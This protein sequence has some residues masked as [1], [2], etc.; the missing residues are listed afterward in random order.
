MDFNDSFGVLEDQGALLSEVAR[1]INNGVI[2]TDR[3]DRVTWVNPGFEAMSGYSLSE[4]LGKKPGSLLH[5]EKTDP[6]T[7]RYMNERLLSGDAFSCEVLHYRRNAEPYW[8]RIEC[9][10]VVFQEGRFNGHIS[11]YNDITAEKKHQDSLRHN[12][13]IHR[14]VLGTLYDAVITTDIRGRIKSVNPALEK[15]FGYSGQDL[16]GQPITRLMPPEI[17]VA[18]PGFMRAYAT[19]SRPDSPIMGNLR[20][21]QGLRS[22][23]SRFTLRIAVT[24]TEVNSERLLVAALHDISEI[25]QREADLERFRKTLDHTLDC[26]FMFDAA[27]LQFFY[28]NRGAEVQ[29]GYTAEEMMSMH[30]YDIKPEYTK[31]QFLELIAPLVSGEKQVLNFQTLHR[32]KT[33]R[34]IPV[35]VFLQ[36][37][38]LADE[39]PRFIAVV[40]DISEQQKQREAIEKLAYYDPLTNLPNRR[41]IRRALIDCMRRSAE[42]GCFCAVM[43][44]DL[45]DFKTVNDTLGHRIGDDLLIEVSDRFASVIGD[46]GTLARLGGDEFLIVVESSA[47]DRNKTL[48]AITGLSRALL[49]S[50][51]EPASA[52]KNA[53]AISTSIGVVLFQGQSSTVSDLMRMADIAMYD[54]KK[55][56][57]NS[58]SVFGEAMQ[59]RLLEEQSMSV[60]LNA[61]LSMD[62]EIVPWFQIKVD[63]N[64]RVTGFEALVRWIHPYRGI[65]SPGSF[66]ELAERQNLMGALSDQ[67]LALSCRT[68]S[69]WRERFDVDH[70]TVAV[71]VSQSQL[72]TRDFPEKVRQ[73]LADTGLPPSA[74]I[75][76]ITESAVAENIQHS[77]WQMNQ[78][79]GLGVRFSMDDFGTGYS[80]LSYLRQLPISELKIDR[81]FVESLLQ[82]EDGFAIVRAILSLAAG[83]QLS[84]VAEGIEREEQ[85]R[86]LKS[87]GC[88]GFQGYFF[89]KPQSAGD[90]EALLGQHFP[91]RPA[92]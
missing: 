75:L 17:G 9:K 58:F 13:Q 7:V 92:T 56:G 28:V 24:E 34:D 30:P 83:L 65:L 39:A 72:A 5:G 74:L 6:D 61:A 54:A 12:L 53:R 14:A 52:L 70:L 42:S 47:T 23:G 11:I 80:S 62:D 66:L 41:L 16:I 60:E 88:R 49:A 8:V 44:T 27:T 46:S 22:D 48:E 86:A 64:G 35:D 71:N 77:T 57:K 26:V 10:P 59:R 33:G 63:E 76:E 50:A 19:G 89:G 40:R 25:E 91:A 2:V 78:L 87:M 79:L 29:V 1:Q 73:V 55:K 3:Q 68:L 38:E 36:Y 43:L 20:S 84:V 37:V 67:I 4:M 15:M 69:D 31:S 18:H 90:V 82:D 21:V 51:S 81:S 45:D 32:H 85:W